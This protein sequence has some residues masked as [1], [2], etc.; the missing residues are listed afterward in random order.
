MDVLQG[1]PYLKT[2]TPPVP[3]V[4]SKNSNQ[5][6]DTIPPLSH[7]MMSWKNPSNQLRITG[8]WACPGTPR[9]GRWLSSSTTNGLALEEPT[10]ASCAFAHTPIIP[11]SGSS[12][13][14]NTYSVPPIL[15]LSSTPNTPTTCSSPS[16]GINF[17]HY[18]SCLNVC[19]LLAP[20]FPNC[21]WIHVIDCLYKLL[22]QRASQEQL[23]IVPSDMWRPLLILHCQSFT[24]ILPDEFHIWDGY[25]SY[26]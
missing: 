12:P 21:I 3:T 5:Q 6:Q 15:P 25:E 22:H 17:T 4:S 2:Q 7:Q 18:Y 16:T 14:T 20:L 19:L 8:L 26:K 24:E 13:R 9:W 10:T 11:L 23:S 1:C